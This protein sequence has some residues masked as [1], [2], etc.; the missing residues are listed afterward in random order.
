MA[1]R[2]ED[3]VLSLLWL[4]LLLWCKCDPCPRNLCIVGMAKKKKK[5][6]KE[7]KKKNEIFI[8]RTL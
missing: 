2:V 4:G 7:K 6:K 5:K 1:Q 3:P 8:L